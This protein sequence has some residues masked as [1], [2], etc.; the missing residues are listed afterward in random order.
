VAS[1]SKHQRGYLIPLRASIHTWRRRWTNDEQGITGLETAIILIAF[2][3]VASVFA[4]TVMTAGIYSSQKANEAVNAAIEEVRSSIRATGN[5]L[6]YRGEV[7]TDGD[8]STTADRVG[9][10]VQVRLELRVAINGVPIDVTPAFQLNPTNGSLESSGLSNTLVVDYLGSTVLAE[11]TAW[12]V[13]F[14][15][16]NDGDFSLEASERA[17]LTV[18]LVEY[19]YDPTAGLYYS[20]G[21]GAADPFLD[22][23]VDLLG[24]HESFSLEVSPVRG[25]PFQVERVTPQSLNPILNLH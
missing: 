8:S 10:V 23:V 20:L 9:A 1:Y 22:D 5:V 19:E 24:A 7:D 21:G 2:V 14:S 6:A 11:N 25:A 17:L 3:V 13:E 4:Y 15:G 12:T 18:W 16:T